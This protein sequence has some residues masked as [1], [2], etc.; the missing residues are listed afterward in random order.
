MRQSMSF[1]TTKKRQEQEQP[2]VQ[3]GKFQDEDDPLFFLIHEI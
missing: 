1:K 2:L 3:E